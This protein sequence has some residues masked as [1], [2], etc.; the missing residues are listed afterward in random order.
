MF[1]LVEH[2]ILVFEDRSKWNDLYKKMQ[3]IRTGIRPSSIVCYISACQPYLLASINLYT[4]SS[5][6]PNIPHETH[7]IEIE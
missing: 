7:S 1:G 4:V 6:G 2:D 3:Q 5:E